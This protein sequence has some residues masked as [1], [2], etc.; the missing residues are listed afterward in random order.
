M[1]DSKKPFFL[2]KWILGLFMW[3][4]KALFK[5]EDDAPESGTM[6]MSAW[7]STLVGLCAGLVMGAVSTFVKNPD[8]ILSILATVAMV[9]VLGLAGYFIYTSCKNSSATV[10]MKVFRSIVLVVISCIL[11]GLGMFIGVWAFIILLVIFV[12]W[13]VLFFIGGGSGKKGKYDV[14]LDDGTGLYKRHDMTLGV[15]YEDDYGNT[16]EKNLD[17]TYS[18]R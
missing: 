8:K 14:I 10:G 5:V 7:I 4:D 13:I 9:G 12:L 18:K 1:A 2:K 15:Y 16:Y 11:A 6:A 17:G 3:V